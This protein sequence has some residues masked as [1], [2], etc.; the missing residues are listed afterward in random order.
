M[1]EPLQYENVASAFHP[2]NINP[3]P[4]TPIIV[5][6]LSHS[7]E[8]EQNPMREMKW[9]KHKESI[10][11]FEEALQRIE[12]LGW[13]ERSQNNISLTSR[14]VIMAGPLYPDVKQEIRQ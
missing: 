7:A 3:Q 11:E 2:D 9:E 5:Y 6:L 4:S 10:G 13:I 14:G 1:I 8:N 12:S